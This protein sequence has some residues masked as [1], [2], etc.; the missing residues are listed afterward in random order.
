[1][2]LWTTKRHNL[3]KISI[4][5]I[6]MLYKMCGNIMRDKI[7]NED[8]CIRYAQENSYNGL[9]MRDIELTNSIV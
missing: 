9:V 5:E 1:M 4:V 3:Q 6:H 2:Q 8:I 7:R